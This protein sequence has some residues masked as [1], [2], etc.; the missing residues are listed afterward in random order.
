ME[1]IF[2]LKRVKTKKVITL[3]TTSRGRSRTADAS[4]RSN[5]LKL[6]NRRAR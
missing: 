5:K 1:S 4:P 6:K 2:F 3:S